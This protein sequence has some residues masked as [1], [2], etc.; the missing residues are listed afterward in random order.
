[1]PQ[2]SQVIGSLTAESRGVPLRLFYASRT[3]SRCSRAKPTICLRNCVLRLLFSGPLSWLT[4]SV[5]TE[6]TGWPGHGAPSSLSGGCQEQPG[7][8]KRVA[9]PSRHALPGTRLP[10]SS[11]AP[12]LPC[13]QA[14]REAPA[15]DR[16]PVGLRPRS[17]SDSRLSGKGR[18]VPRWGMIHF[19]VMESAAQPE[20]CCQP[21]CHV[22]GER[23][24]AFF[25][26]RLAGS[27]QLDEA[28]SAGCA[29]ACIR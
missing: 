12:V 20:G 27:G 25:G 22:G 13:M 19:T 29:R 9:Q 4:T 1:M 6:G 18:A 28:P 5:P 16:F 10:G 3:S 15:P 26:G 8:G 7:T 14:C 21:N 17:P 23:I 24:R 11:A 2:P